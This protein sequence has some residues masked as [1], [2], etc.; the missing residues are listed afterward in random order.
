MH[1]ADDVEHAALADQNDRFSLNRRDA[2]RWVCILI[3]YLLY[4]V[5]VG[6]N[7]GASDVFFPPAHDVPRVHVHDYYVQFKFYC[8]ARLPAIH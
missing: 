5:S 7:F 8:V 3:L 4:F 6:L 1:D 2:P